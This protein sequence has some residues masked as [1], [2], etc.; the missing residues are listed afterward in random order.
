MDGS[1]KWEPVGKVKMRIAGNELQMAVPRAALGLTK[2]TFDFK[3]ADNLPQPCTVENFY[4][5]GDVAPAGRFNFRYV[6]PWAV[7]L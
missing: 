6:K 3:W 7:Q 2:S 5:T 4:T 1:W